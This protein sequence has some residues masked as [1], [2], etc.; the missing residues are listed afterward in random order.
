MIMFFH[1][2]TYDISTPPFC[3]SCRRFIP[4]VVHLRHSCHSWAEGERWD[5]CKER[6]NDG[7]VTRAV[8]S[9]SS[10]S[11][12]VSSSLPRVLRS[13][14]TLVI[15]SPRVPSPYHPL[16]EARGRSVM[17]T[18][19]P[20]HRS[21]WGVVWRRDEHEVERAQAGGSSGWL[22]VSL[23]ASF[24]SHVTPYVPHIPLTVLFR[25][26][27]YASVTQPNGE[28][29]RWEEASSEGTEGR[30][31][32]TEGR[33]NAGPDKRREEPDTYRILH[34]NSLYVPFPHHHK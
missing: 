33:Q 11:W 19:E 34:S 26:V 25:S 30:D 15:H 8:P 18:E 6:V 12:L 24:P 32:V 14:G 3:H 16:R 17:T 21:G 7:G 29:M 28:R 27:R 10:F 1:L 31:G 4:T 9:V 22:V 13:L 2:S 23:V 5:G 20:R